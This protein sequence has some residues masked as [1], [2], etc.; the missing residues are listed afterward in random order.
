MPGIWT[1]EGEGWCLTRPKGFPDEDTLH[2]LIQETPGMLPLAGEPTLVVLGRE[3]RLGSGYADLVGVET[4]GRPII[5]EVKL[6]KNAEAKRAVV[7]QVLAYAAWLHG[8]TTTQLEERLSG[9]TS[10]KTATLLFSTPFLSL[11][12]QVRLTERRSRQLLRKTCATAGSGW[13]LSW[14]RC[15]WNSRHWLPIWRTSP[16]GWRST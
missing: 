15:R 4:T 11:P 9:R 16:T 2:S 14:T 5:I 6:S 13:S 8:F 1:N 3:V 12:K 7:A 10:K